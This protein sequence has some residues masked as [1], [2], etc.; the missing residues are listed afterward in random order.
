MDDNTRVF[1]FPENGNNDL[2]TLLALSGNRGWGGMSGWGGGLIGFILGA[3]VNNNGNG[4]F[5]GGNNNTNDLIMQAVTSKGELQQQAINQLA[6]TLNADFNQVNTAIN[7]VS[8]QLCNIGSQLGMSSLQVINAMQSGNA[9]ISAQL[10]QGFGNLQNTMQV[11]AANDN[12]AICNQTTTI[13]NKLDSMEDA[14][15]DREIN[16][17]TAKVAQLESQNFTT[18]VVQQAISPVLGQLANI[19]NEVEAIKRCQPPTITLPNNQYT[20]VPTLY[21]NVGADFLGSYLA[22]RII[23]ATGNNGTTDT[24][25]PTTQG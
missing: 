25:T 21:A 10:C 23:A 17:L 15:K 16:A 24:T 2:A 12:F 9:N 22:H 5:G 20:A 19:S 14:R 4:L 3:L 13:L 6:T 11:N 7:A 1:S 18:G 8:T